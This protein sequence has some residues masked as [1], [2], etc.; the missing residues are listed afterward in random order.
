MDV[1]NLYIRIKS[2]RLVNDSFWALLG[3]V[4]NKGLALI[5][6][7]VVAR[8]LGKDLYGEYGVIKNALLYLAVFSTFGLG[9]SATKFVAELK[10][11]RDGKL[12][13]IT[14]A[15]IKISIIFSGIICLLTIIFANSL[16]KFLDISSESFLLQTTGIVI[17]LN[18]LSTTQTGILSGLKQYK[19]LAKI[20]LVVGLLT[21]FST[22]ILTY[23]LGILGA[24]LSLLVSNALNCILLNI[25]IRKEIYN[26]TYP[27]IS[28]RSIV[29][30]MIIFS[31][32]IAM[33]ESLYSVAYWTGMMILIKLSNYGE[34]GLYS[35][36]T[37]WA[38][39]ILF[40]PGVLQNVMLSHLS[41]IVGQAHN[42]LLKKMLAINFIV[43]VIPFCIIFLCTNWITSLY[44][45]SFEGLGIVLNIS[46]V[47]TISNCLIQ[48]LIQEYISTGKT[49]ELFFI[50]LGRDIVSLVLS[51][52]SIVHFVKNGAFWFCLSSLIASII[53]LIVLLSYNNRLQVNK[54]SKITAE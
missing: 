13:C 26:T 40:I 34:V 22:I 1:N 12:Q 39:A 6:G 27:K 36:A 7:I 8:W 14:R 47:T 52:F 44:G 31:F 9:F 42:S 53:C 32:P 3:S 16:C 21:A 30:S 45:A 38:G 51:Y 28:D 48:V 5:A 33:Q 4:L 24:I 41:S 43:T 10:G 20:N 54:V 18:S 23:L 29:K 50:R 37:Q 11:D 49:W 17:V 25:I 2:S 15:A 35:A 46:I 19:K